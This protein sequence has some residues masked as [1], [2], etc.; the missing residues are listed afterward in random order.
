C[1][2]GNITMIG[3]TANI[4]ALGM[5]EKRAKTHIRF[6]EW[7]KIGVLSAIVTLLIAWV[8]IVGLRG[9]MPDRSA[10]RLP[11]QGTNSNH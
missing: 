10:S 7:L 3:S 4:V 11:S 6:F 2:G 1:L 8:L 9:Y 5:L